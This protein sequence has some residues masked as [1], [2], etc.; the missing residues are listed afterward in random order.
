M[1]LPYPEPLHPHVTL[2]MSRNR[3]RDTR[4]ELLLRRLLH[5]RGL[6]FR[7]DYPIRTD[8]IKVRPDVVF[9]R[10]RLAIFVD[11]CFWHGCPEHGNIPTRNQSYW[12]PKLER[13]RARDSLVT[14]A[15]IRAGWVVLRVWEHEPVTAVAAR[16]LESL[17]AQGEPAK[18][19][20]AGDSAH[21]IVSATLVGRGDLEARVAADI[22]GIGAARD[23]SRRH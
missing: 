4:P 18:Q 21:R 16:I 23:D 1:S 7:V 19:F 11:G 5:A 13:N 12:V 20:E 8:E 14:A 17:A 22:S 3:R 2:R 6:R 9:T 15:L 10:R